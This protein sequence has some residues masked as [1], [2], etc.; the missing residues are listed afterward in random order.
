MFQLQR[1]ELQA[2][3]LHISKSFKLY[4]EDLLLYILATLIPFDE[5]RTCFFF[6]AHEYRLCTM[7]NL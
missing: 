2:Y 5:S 4:C 7:S 1:N 6:I 3:K